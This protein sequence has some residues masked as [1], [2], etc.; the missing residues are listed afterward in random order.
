M[1]VCLDAGHYAKYNRS[2]GIPEYWESERMWKLTE[3]LATA[4]KKK[5]VTVVKTRTNQAAD[6]AL[7]NRGKASKGC[8][9]FLSIHSNA[10]GNGMNESVDYP[11]AYVMLDGST[12]EIGM[13]LAEIV[14]KQMGT[15]QKGRT[16]TRATSSGGEYYG[17]LRGAKAVGTPG[18]ILE[19]SFHTNTKATNWLLSD[20]NLKKLA[21]A[22]AVCIAD[23][24]KKNASKTTTTTA[25]PVDKVDVDPAMGFTKAY[26]KTYTVNASGLN[27]RTGAGTTKKII[28]VLH[29]GDKFTCYG[30]FTNADG[31]TWLLGVDKTGQT[32][33]CSKYY[34]K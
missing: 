32:G 15:T 20:D 22:E 21:E 3:L 10:V 4:L 2:P 27:M 26:A 24:L 1:K 11:V 31:I 29:R 18:V 17:V 9:L 34:L 13:M 12:T 5:G 6:L 25:K 7:V 30:Y 19:H 23:W 8:D 14:Q 33:F 28:K 16:S